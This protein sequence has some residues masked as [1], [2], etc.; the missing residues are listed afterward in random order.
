MMNLFTIHIDIM[1][2]LYLLSYYVHPAIAFS[3]KPIVSDL[4]TVKGTSPSEGIRSQISKE[5]FAY[6]SAI[7]ANVEIRVSS[8]EKGLGVFATSKI[9]IGTLIGCYNGETLTYSQAEA[10]YSWSEEAVKSEE[11]IQWINSRVQSGQGL[12]GHYLF[13]M[14]NGDFVD[15][16]DAN[17]SSWCRFMNH[18]EERTEQCNVKAFLRAE[19]GDQIVEFPLMYTIQDIDLNEELCFDYGVNYF[20][21]DLKYT[22]KV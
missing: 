18:A 16:E 19:T 17:V 10:R 13:T 7:D 2:V 12:T 22:E 14:P 9:P 20:V 5:S 11:D 3:S 4:R 15:A 21:E 8:E 6:Q 1:I